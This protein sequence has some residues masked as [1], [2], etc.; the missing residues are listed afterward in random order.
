MDK[1]QFVDELLNI[2]KVDKI[3]F[4]QRYD[5]EHLFEKLVDGNDAQIEERV[6]EATSDLEDSVSDLEDR[7][8]DLENVIDDARF[9]LAAAKEK[10]DWSEVEVVIDDL[11]SAT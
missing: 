1:Y 7:V 8:N 5:L 3:D 9:A 2:L 4:I 6:T 10:E 11:R